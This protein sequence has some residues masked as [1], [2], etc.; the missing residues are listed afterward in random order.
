MTLMPDYVWREFNDCL[1]IWD[2]NK[3][4]MTVTNGIEKVL[5]EIGLVTQISGKIIVYRDSENEYNQVIV[6]KN[7]EFQ[8][9]ETPAKLDIMMKV[10]TAVIDN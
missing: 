7:G 3:G 2:Q 4:N 8:G 1:V 6:N 10:T 5:K 9:Y